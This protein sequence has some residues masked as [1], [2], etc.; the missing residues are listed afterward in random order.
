VSDQE[1]NKPDHSS[2]KEGVSQNRQ[3]QQREQEG[4][5]DYSY[6]GKVHWLLVPLAVFIAFTASYFNDVALF[7]ALKRSF[8]AGAAFWVL[9]EIL[10]FLLKK[11]G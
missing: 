10:D 5:N 9:A 7:E 2:Q 11:K 1:N 6:D 4:K 8:Y 3:P